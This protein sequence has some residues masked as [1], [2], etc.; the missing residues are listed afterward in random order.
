RDQWVQAV[1]FDPARSGRTL[2]GRAAPL[3]R[4]ALR[5]GSGERPCAVGALG[6][7]MIA[8]LHSGS[9][10][11]RNNRRR[12]GALARVVHG[13]D[14]V[15]LVES[16]RYG[17]ELAF[18]DALQEVVGEARFVRSGRFHAPRYGKLGSGADGKVELPAVEAA[19]LAS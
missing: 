9:L 18:A 11:K 7:A 15:A 1:G 19:A 3:R 12:S 8:A 16:C 14:V 17:L 13:G 2:A 6:R 10:A 5:V 4:I